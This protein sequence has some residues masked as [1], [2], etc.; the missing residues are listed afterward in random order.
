MNKIYRYF[1]LSLFSCLIITLFTFDASAGDTT[2]VRVHDQVGWTWY[3]NKFEIAE[4]PSDT[5][6]FQKILMHYTLGCPSIGC[7]DWDYTTMIVA[8]HPTGEF[9]STLT[10]APLFTANGQSYDS[11]GIS[12]NE[13]W[14]YYY[15]TLTMS[16]DSVVSQTLFIFYF[17]DPANPLAAT[18]SVKVWSTNYYNYIFNS[19]GNIIDSV[20]VSADTTLINVY[21][22]T[23]VQFE[24][25]AAIELARVITPY[26][27]NYG[28]TWKNTWTFDVT[29][30]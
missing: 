25:E 19:N 18:D 16:T 1:A 3:G 9:D 13:N 17:E 24:V 6:R 11:L 15:D 27:G 20:F 22:T 10:I 8:M 14:V 21:D 12:F 30:Y 29:D 26:G 2:R 4:F 7:S 28:A 5:A 23:Y